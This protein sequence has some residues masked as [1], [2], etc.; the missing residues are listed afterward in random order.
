MKYKYAR[1]FVIIILSISLTGCFLFPPIKND[2]V[3]WTV[4]V[5]LDADNN[6]ESAGIDD[7]NEMEIVGSSDDVNIVVQVDRIPYSVLATNNQGYADDVSNGDWTNTRRYYI[8]QDFDS[9]IINSQLIGGDLG[10]LNMGDPQTLVDFASWATINYP[11][12]KYLLVIWNHGGGFRSLEYTTKD[13]A[14]DD[15]SGGDK[16]T[17]PEL[18]YALSDINT[19]I[20]KKIDIVGMDACLM[21]MTEVAY[22][23]KDY[24]DILVASEENEPAD[25]WPY[26]TILGELAGN[27]FISSEQLAVDIVDEYIFSYPY[28]NVTQSAIDLSY[29]DTLAGQ[30]SNLALAIMSDSSTTK[31]KY[32]L[33]SVSSQYYGDWDFI[34]LY[35]FCNQLLAY[36]NSLDVKNI[37]LNIQQTL[38]Y[39]VIKSGYSGGSVSGSKGL[40]IY[41]PYTAYHYYYNYTNFAQDTFW[42]EMLSYLGY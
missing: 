16:I 7:I 40:S 20:G 9:Y 14:W 38:N 28:N 21:A 26:D 17:M 27:P 37:A 4:M 34:D 39:S 24:A 2:T 13:I 12:K 22:Q 5:Y 6:L 8:T 19:Q 36:S 15:T 42:D 10:E 31:S 18:E 29:I 35:D 11:A 41:F 33:A 1:I 3:E 23:I 30:L 25:G 32:V